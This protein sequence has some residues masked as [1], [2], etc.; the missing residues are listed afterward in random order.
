LGCAWLLS[1]LFLGVVALAHREDAGG[2][3][4]T[5]SPAPVVTPAVEVAV[6]AMHKGQCYNSSMDPDQGSVTSCYDAHD[7]EVVGSVRL[8]AGG[9]FSDAQL[10]RLCRPLLTAQLAELVDQ[11]VLSLVWSLPTDNATTLMCRLEGSIHVP[12]LN[13][14]LAHS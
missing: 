2:G 9:A 6:G 14:P 13:S 12:P 10:T 1:V 3:G 7:G 4:Q 8:P 11:E 5:A